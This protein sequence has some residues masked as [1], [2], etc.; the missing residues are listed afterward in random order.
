M[1]RS[2]LK[3]ISANLRAD[4]P[5][6]KQPCFLQKMNS[7]PSFLPVSPTPADS[8]WAVVENP[9]RLMRTYEFQSSTH[10]MRF[11]VEFLEEQDQIRHPAKMTIDENVM[12][13]EIYTRDLNTIT[14]LDY[15]LARLADLIY[16]DTTI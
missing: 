6:K 5:E 9:R 2:L 16:A 1:K 8:S 11:V 4:M 12:H 15:Q 14:E 13:V 10:R 3:E 7:M